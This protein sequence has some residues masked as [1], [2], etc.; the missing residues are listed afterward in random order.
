M[1]NVYQVLRERGYVAQTS[2]DEAVEKL[3]A[4]STT[5]YEGFDPTAD[6][7]AGALWKYAC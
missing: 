5:I 7:L 3:L 6:S 1:S 4:G 2:D